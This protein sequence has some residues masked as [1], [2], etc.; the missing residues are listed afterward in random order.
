MNIIYE[1]TN[2][3]IEVAPILDGNEKVITRISYTYQA[4]DTES[5]KFAGIN[6]YCDFKLAEGSVFTPFDSLTESIVKSWLETKVLT[7]GFV[8]ILETK[9]ADEVLSMYVS[10]ASPWETSVVEEPAV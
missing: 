6:S 8:A 1:F 2:L 3:K 7:E 9:V 5:G 4:T 10:V